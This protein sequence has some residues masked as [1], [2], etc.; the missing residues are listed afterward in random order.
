MEPTC[1]DMLIA[2]TAEAHIV[3]YAVAQNLRPMIRRRPG[4]EDE[5]SQ[6]R[7]GAVFV[8][9]EGVRAAV[10]DLPRTR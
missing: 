2:T 5:R 3:M 6:I 7:P 8:W 4:N 9:E 10:G 1:T